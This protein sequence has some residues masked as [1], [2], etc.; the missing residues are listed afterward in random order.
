MKLTSLIALGFVT[1]LPVIGAAAQ[2]PAAKAP[3][4]TERFEVTAIK[5]VRPTLV[6]TIAALQK[7]DAAGAMAAFEDY[8]SGWNGIEVYV[9][10]RS[11]EMYDELEKNL[12]TKISEGLKAPKPDTSK[13]LPDAKM[14]LTKYDELIGMVQKGSPLNPLY[15][16]VARMRIVRAHLREVNPALKAGDIAKAKKSYGAFSDHWDD[17]EELVSSRS[18]PTY[19]AIESGMTQIETALKP[20][21]PNADEVATMVTGVM[22][23]YNAV[24]A[25]IA[26]DAKKAQ[27]L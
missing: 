23:K 4:K 20:A 19:I 9:N 10:T 1:M 17:I 16:D 25:T 2:A 7:Q 8:D 3:A 5:A 12:Q 13:L 21:K 18:R 6:K 15:D 22:E 27:G 14:M 11:K 26:N 24:L